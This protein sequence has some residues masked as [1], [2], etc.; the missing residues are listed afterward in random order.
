VLLPLAHLEIDGPQNEKTIFM[1]EKALLYNTFY[2]K[3]PDAFIY[4][5]N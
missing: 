2:E 4:L 3:N 1:H 5:L